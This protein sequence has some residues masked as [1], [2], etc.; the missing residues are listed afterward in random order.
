MVLTFTRCRDA[1]ES[2]GERESHT[3]NCWGNALRPKSDILRFPAASKSRFSGYPN[4]IKKKPSNTINKHSMEKYQPK[5]GFPVLSSASQLAHLW[6][7]PQDFKKKFQIWYELFFF[8]TKLLCMSS[9]EFF[10]IVKWWNFFPKKWLLDTECN[11]RKL[12]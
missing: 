7:P 9:A 11:K 2:M 3:L 12:W 4:P 6:I 1:N 8:F 5:T 10:L